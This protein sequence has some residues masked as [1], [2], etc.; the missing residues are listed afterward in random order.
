MSFIIK[1]LLSFLLGIGVSIF[2]AA[3]YVL[4]IIVLLHF[5]DKNISDEIND[6]FI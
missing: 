5:K 1:L 2:A 6:W 3:F 4:W